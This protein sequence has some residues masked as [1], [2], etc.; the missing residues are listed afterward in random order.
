M[1]EQGQDN[2]RPKAVKCNR[3]RIWLVVFVVVAVSIA[4]HL[5]R[6]A[7]SI[8]KELA[9]IEAAR[10]IPDSENA[11]LLY[12]R[13]LDEHPLTLPKFGFSKPI[14]DRSY[15]IL[16][17]IAKPTDYPD[18][19]VYV[20][21]LLEA[22][23]RNDCRWSLSLEP[24]V[25]L[26][27]RAVR[28]EMRKWAILLSELAREDRDHGLFDAA[29]EK[30]LCLIRMAEHC[31]QQRTREGMFIAA[32][33]E[34]GA[35]GGFNRLI[36]NGNATE[37][38]LRIIDEVV[39]QLQADWDQ[40]WRQMSEVEKLYAEYW[41]KQFTLRRRLSWIG[42]D[43]ELHY[44]I[45]PFLLYHAMPK[46]YARRLSWRRGTRIVI[47]LR[48]CKDRNGHWPKRLEDLASL[49]PPEIFIDPVNDGK[50][51]YRLR[52]DAFVLYSKGKDGIDD[53]VGWDFAHPMYGPGHPESDDTAIYTGADWRSIP[54]DPDHIDVTR[55]HSHTE[56]T[57]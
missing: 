19:Y 11:A 2:E 33:P 15:G 21:M 10:S 12:Y 13:I 3:K 25:I 23:E 24:K 57:K 18:Y 16:S 44:E 8:H 29:F 36:V 27:R 39:S 54:P 49:T 37:T 5:I 55:P 20:P 52:G 34:C 48:R 53:H 1:P 32:S 42:I 17:P 4:V 28:K 22:A 26:R 6:S 35:L 30:Y 45:L 9:A 40:A 50:F 41:K 46:V 31:Y 14:A 56:Q 51:V 7:G 38:Q 47:A 43:K